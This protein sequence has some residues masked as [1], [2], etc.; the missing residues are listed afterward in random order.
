MTVRVRQ[1]GRLYS[2]MIG[3]PSAINIAGPEEQR[4]TA[5]GTESGKWLSLPMSR[6]PRV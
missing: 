3:I 5:N 4:R 1:V 2:P 6:I